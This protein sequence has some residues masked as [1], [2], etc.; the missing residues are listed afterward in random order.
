MLIHRM[1]CFEAET[2][3][4][5]FIME[6]RKI[7]SASLDNNNDGDQSFLDKSGA[8][9]QLRDVLAKVIENR[10]SDPISFFAEY[11]ECLGDKVDRVGQAHRQICLTHY[12]KPAF[13]SNIMAA[14]DIL[15][16]NKVHDRKGKP[17]KRE[18]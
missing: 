15:S 5:K 18:G 1:H 16:Q 12:S 17:I 14:Y 11:F 9:D 8:T 2:N 13:H 10:P 4:R 3:T 6:K 7:P